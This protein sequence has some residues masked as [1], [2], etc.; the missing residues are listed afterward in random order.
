[1]TA[2]DRTDVQL[3]QSIGLVHPSRMGRTP[4]RKVEP[5]PANPVLMT[6]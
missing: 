3:L 6:G 2:I 5:E 4:R 1:M